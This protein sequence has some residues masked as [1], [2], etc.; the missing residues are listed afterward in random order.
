MLL[1]LIDENVIGPCM[2]CAKLSVK[3][4]YKRLYTEIPPARRSFQC[5]DG[6][7]QIY[8]VHCLVSYSCGK[9]HKYIS[10]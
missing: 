4:S 5:S 9:L 1:A 10:L 7:Q 2:S 3:S 8:K 6:E